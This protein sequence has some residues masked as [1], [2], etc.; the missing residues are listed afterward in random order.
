MK[1]R[2]DE[3]EFK[4]ISENILSFIKNVFE[5][6][7]VF[8]LLSSG[9]VLGA[10]RH[11]GFIP[12]DDDIDIYIFRKDVNRVINIFNKLNNRQYKLLYLNCVNYSLPLMKIVDSSTILYQKGR[13]REF[14]LGV[15][16]DVFILDNLP[17]DSEKSNK[18]CKKLARYQKLWSF[19][20]YKIQK[21]KSIKQFIKNGYLSLVS[22]RGSRYWAIKLDKL[23]QKYCEEKCDYV[24]SLTFTG[25]NIKRE[26]ACFP[27]AMLE[28]TILHKFESGEYPIPKK[29][30][31]YLTILYG[32]WRELPPI[33]K[34]V[35]RH[36]IEAYY[37]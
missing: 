13:R 28:D 16:V 2:I 17:N 37:K 7:N 24:S 12:W 15:W 27:R 1:Q 8:Y 4:I 23:A 3:K 33:E 21:P 35:S 5:E 19:A 18:F 26:D 14:P 25:C 22:I 32:N 20:E 9:T 36:A 10:V 29:F 34:R 6:N 11:D 31:E 30:D